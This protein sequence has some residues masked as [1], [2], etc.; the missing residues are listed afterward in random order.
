MLAIYNCFSIPFEIAYAPPEM[1]TNTFLIANT[2]ID[3]A[4]AADIM[5]AFRTTFYDLETGDEIFS[6][7]R[8]A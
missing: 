7:K 3:L 1:D 8:T 6:T 2:I 5:V 4:F